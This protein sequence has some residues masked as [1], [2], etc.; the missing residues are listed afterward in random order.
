MYKK[1]ALLTL[2][3]V[4]FQ[5]V[6]ANNDTDAIDWVMTGTRHG[7]YSLGGGVVAGRVANN[8]LS[9]IP[10]ATPRVV[11]LGAYTIAGL[12]AGAMQTG[13]QNPNLV[14]A[15]SQRHALHAAVGLSAGVAAMTLLKRSPT[16]F[17]FTRSFAK[18][19][20]AKAYL[21]RSTLKFCRKLHKEVY[22]NSVNNFDNYQKMFAYFTA[23]S[24]AMI[25]NEVADAA[26]N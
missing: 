2:T 20:T 16:G 23:G 21:D 26:K 14:F 13:F 11:S 19:G 25:A 22:E 17:P 7:A 10:R 15:D 4:G 8:L 3:I 12:T 6:A 1:I 9:K 24:A 5:H 18:I